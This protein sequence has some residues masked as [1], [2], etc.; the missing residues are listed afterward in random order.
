MLNVCSCLGF[1]LLHSFD[2]FRCRE[3]MMFRLAVIDSHMRM[4]RNIVA[5]NEMI[6]PIDEILFQVVNESG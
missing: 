6:D 2:V 3:K 4:A 1:S 5:V